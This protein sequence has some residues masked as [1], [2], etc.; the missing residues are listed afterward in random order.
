VGL[1]NNNLPRK[2]LGFKT[3]LEVF[4]EEKRKV[5]VRGGM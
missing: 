1:N 5:A 4:T 3:P 2:R